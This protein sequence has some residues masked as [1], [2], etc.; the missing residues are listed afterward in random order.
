MSEQY[1]RRQKRL[2]DEMVSI[3]QVRVIGFPLS[4]QRGTL[5]S[6]LF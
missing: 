4:P 5:D 2:L 6:L 3:K 1:F